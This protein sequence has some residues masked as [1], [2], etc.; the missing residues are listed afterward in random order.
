LNPQDPTLPA[1]SQIAA[2]IGL[3]AGQIPRKV[4]PDYARV[5]LYLL[6][7]TRSLDAPGTPLRRF[8]FIGDTR[9]L[10]GTAFAN[11]CLASG[12]HGIAFIGSESKEPAS[13]QMAAT[14]EG[15]PLYLANRWAALDDFDRYCAAQGC[16]VDECC[17][18]VIDLDK[19]A[20]GARGRNAL[21]IDQARVQ[22]V[23]DTVAALLG[24]S[25]DSTSF[26]TAYDLLNQP[27]YHPFTLDNQDYLAYICLILSSGLVKLETL[28][29]DIRSE[30]MREFKEFV[31][32]VDTFIQRRAKPSLIN[33][34]EEIYSNVLAG[35]PT[36]FKSFRRNEFLATVGRMGYLADDTPVD[37]LLRDEIVITQEVRLTAL[38]WR[39]RGALIFGL[40]DKPDE[41]SVPTPT[42]AEQGY[43]PIHR[44]ETHV[45]G[46]RVD[47]T[48]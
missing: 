14:Q 10:D 13:V 2:A 30:R 34:H 42:L 25:F 7:H 43:R 15:K 27:A 17:A 32:L 35:D 6:Q 18:V 48:D 4:E 40:S 3:P 24:D 1:L 36:P 31:A 22:A 12:W 38:E 21:M 5:I 29:E 8:V 46:S 44:T 26:R 11:M 37:Q 20:I 41:A 47:N 45:V 16:P 23:Q 19:T 28:V 33:L 9:L 39:G